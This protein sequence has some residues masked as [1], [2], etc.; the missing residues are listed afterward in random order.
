M[1]FLDASWSGY[2]AIRRE[3]GLERAIGPL[4]DRDA[5]ARV[6]DA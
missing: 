1:G 3:I 6:F 4:G 2:T 5:R